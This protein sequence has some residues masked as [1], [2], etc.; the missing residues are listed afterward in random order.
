MPAASCP[1]R[2]VDDFSTMRTGSPFL[3]RLSAAI[4]PEG[5]DPT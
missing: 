3:V 4:S 2:L 1:M 5:P